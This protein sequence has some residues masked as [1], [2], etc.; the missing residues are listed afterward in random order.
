MPLVNSHT[1]LPSTIHTA[2]TPLRIAPLISIAI[3]VLSQYQNNSNDELWNNIK[4]VFKYLN[5]TKELK[6]TYKKSTNYDDILVG[7][8]DSD[9]GGQ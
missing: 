5:G 7:Y 9:Y 3:N 2:I 4:R 1:V 8:A 6:L